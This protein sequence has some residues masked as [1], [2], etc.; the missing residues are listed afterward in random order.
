MS[1]GPFK[2]RCFNSAVH[3]QELF[4]SCSLQVGCGW[5]GADHLFKCLIAG[6]FQSIIWQFTSTEVYNAWLRA[7]GAKIGRQCWLS[8]MFRCSEFELFEVEDTASM[9]R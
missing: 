7:L 9:C 4:I 2:S 1:A 6:P 5:R 8:E 3:I